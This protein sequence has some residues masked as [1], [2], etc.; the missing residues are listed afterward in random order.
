MR[1]QTSTSPSLTVMTTVVCEQCDEKFQITHPMRLQD[2]ALARR[3]AD[4]LLDR[5]VWDHI[6][7]NKHRSSIQLPALAEASNEI[8]SKGLS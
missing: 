3:Q 5:F 1:N 2:A 8:R 4:W 7:E 6:Q